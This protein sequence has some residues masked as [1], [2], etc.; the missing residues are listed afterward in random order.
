VG[1]LLQNM[2]YDCSSIGC[3]SV[4]ALFILVTT[5]IVIVF[6]RAAVTRRRTV[7]QYQEAE[8]EIS[9]LA[10]DSNSDDDEEGYEYDP[11]MPQIT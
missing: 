4:L 6:I 9:D 5:A 3:R 11:S 8:L 7:R 10:L 2:K 1:E